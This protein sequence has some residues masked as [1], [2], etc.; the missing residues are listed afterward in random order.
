MASAELSTADRIDAIAAVPRALDHASAP[1]AGSARSTVA[2]TDRSDRFVVLPGRHDRSAEVLVLSTATSAG[3]EVLVAVV[4]EVDL[5]T[6]RALSDGLTAAL[7]HPSCATLTV[8]LHG[9]RFLAVRGIEVLDAVRVIAASRQVRF[10]LVAG[11]Y[12]VLRALALCP[13]GAV[14]DVFPTVSAARC[15]TARPDAASGRPA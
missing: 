4:G 7:E 12:P 6:V 13:L 8:D 3:G 11:S 2:L 14:T 1:G 10:A 5:S 9:V 15:V